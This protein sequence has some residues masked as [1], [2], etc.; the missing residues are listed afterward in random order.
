MPIYAQHFFSVLGHRINKA[1]K[2]AYVM[3]LTCWERQKTDKCEKGNTGYGESTEQGRR[4]GSGGEGAG[5]D[6]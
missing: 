3:E 1:E 5:V 6:T 4:R 2:V